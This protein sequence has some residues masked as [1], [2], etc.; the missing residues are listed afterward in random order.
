MCKVLENRSQ[1]D[2]ERMDQ[3]TN[4]LKEARLLAEDADG[5]SDEVFISLTLE[6]LKINFEFLKI[7]IWTKGITQAGLRWRRVGSS[8]RSCQIW[9]LKDHGARGRVESRRKLPQISG[10]I[11]GEG[12]P[13]CWGVQEAAQDLDRQA[14]GSRSSCRIRREDSQEVAEGSRQARRCAFPQYNNESWSII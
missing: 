1:Q 7:Y 3:L 12:Q 5:K 8:W 13:T 6:T 10:S 9:R 11:R 2:E 14:Q 4:Q